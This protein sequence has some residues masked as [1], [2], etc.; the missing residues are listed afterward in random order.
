MFGIQF[1]SLPISHVDHYEV[2][3]VFFRIELDQQVG[4]STCAVRTHR[5]PT[6]ISILNVKCLPHSNSYTTM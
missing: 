1:A 6:P 2:L 4:I 5:A 3:C